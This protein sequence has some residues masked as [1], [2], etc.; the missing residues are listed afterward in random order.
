MQEIDVF[1]R[2][3]A[4]H[5]PP[6]NARLVPSETADAFR[7]RLPPELLASW[8]R[9]GWGDYNEGFLR[10]CDPRPLDPIISL[11]FRDDSELKAAELT[12]VAYT[13]FNT[14]RVW[15]R[16]GRTILIHL[17]EAEVF[18]PSY[19]STINPDTQ[20]PYS[21]AFLAGLLIYDE[22]SLEL[23]DYYKNACAKLGRPD[24]DQVFGYAPALQLGGEWGLDHL[25]RFKAIEHMTFLAQLGPLTLTELT[26]PQPDAPLG[27]LRRVR[28]IGPP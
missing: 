16:A 18:A 7:D 15:D 4:D 21:N 25:H 8:R 10:I 2:I 19:S 9:Y 28:R 3:I 20:R 24:P 17:D 11:I 23:Q 12:V 22:L 14:L 5:G 13:L 6:E 27:R 26:G 1:A